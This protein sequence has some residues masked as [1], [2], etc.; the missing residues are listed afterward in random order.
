MGKKLQRMSDSIPVYIVGD[1]HGRFDL[2][3]QEIKRF[4]IRNCIIICV[5]DLGLGF[6]WKTDPKKE[7][8]IHAQQ[9][10]WFG[11]RNIKFYSIRGNHDDPQF[12][13]GKT[14]IAY[15]NF[16]MIEDYTTFNINGERFLFIGGAISV[17]RSGN[18]RK[19]GFSYWKDEPLVFKP[20][21]IKECDVLITHSAP[22][23]NGPLSKDGLRE[24]ADWENCDKS[25]WDECLQERK[26]ISHIVR[27]SKAKMHYCGHFHSYHWVEQC[28]CYSTIL[29]ILQFKEHRMLIS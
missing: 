21:L 11:R 1:V 5:G 4:D 7:Q 28:N 25:L 14:R 22:T 20:W 13:T 27:E 6:H 12:F 3:Q 16:E 26:D 10:Q 19:E 15:K 2:L 18:H 17:D 8:R 9:N 23:W 24:F 29:A